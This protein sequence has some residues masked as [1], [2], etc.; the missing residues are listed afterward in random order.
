MPVDNASFN[1]LLV[2]LF[3]TVGLAGGVIFLGLF[4]V[5]RLFRIYQQAIRDMAEQQKGVEDRLDRT[6]RRLDRAERRLRILEKFIDE[7]VFIALK[8]MD[9][10]PALVAVLRQKLYDLIR[11][12]N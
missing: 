7:D 4:V 8:S 1:A 2:V 9:G 5:P 3:G 6:E 10:G 12:T 11:E